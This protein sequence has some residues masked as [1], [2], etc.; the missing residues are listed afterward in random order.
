MIVCLISVQLQATITESRLAAIF[1]RKCGGRVASLELRRSGGQAVTKGHKIPNDMRSPRDVLY[2]SIQFEKHES[3]KRALLYH[4]AMLDQA[5]L[6]VSAHY[7]WFRS[8]S[9]MNSS[10]LFRLLPTFYA[11]RRT[12]TSWKVWLPCRRI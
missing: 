9:C 2:A 8:R 6:I 7:T 11:C 4:G 10:R 12:F 3:A 1:Q 5:P